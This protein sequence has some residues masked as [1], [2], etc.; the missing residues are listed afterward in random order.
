MQQS[1]NSVQIVG[2]I[3][4]QREVGA[5]AGATVSVFGGGINPSGEIPAGVLS[6]ERGCANK[7]EPP[8]FSSGNLTPFGKGERAVEFVFL[9]AAKMTFMFKMV[10]DRSLDRYQL[11]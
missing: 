1:T 11:L 3:G 5:T 2:M 8:V 6:E 7:P 10:V 9:A 4:V